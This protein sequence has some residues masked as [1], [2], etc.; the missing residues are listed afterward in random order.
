MLFYKLQKK[1]THSEWTTKCEKALVSLKMDLSTP[2]V[3]YRPIV[4]EILFLY[5]N[6]SFE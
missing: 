6:V 1:Q 4:E 2:S 5:L 3:L